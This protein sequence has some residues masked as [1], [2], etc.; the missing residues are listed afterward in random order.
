MSR[1]DRT[2][3]RKIAYAYVHPFIHILRG[4]LW[5]VM[6]IPVHTIGLCIA[7]LVRDCAIGN[8]FLVMFFAAVKL[9]ELIISLFIL[10]M[11]TV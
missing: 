10:N 6:W 9:F 1:T 5:P 11:D 7:V 8:V 4:P 2:L 3:K